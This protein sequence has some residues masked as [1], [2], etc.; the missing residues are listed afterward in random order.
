MTALKTSLGKRPPAKSRPKKTLIGARSGFSRA[1]FG[2][3]AGIFAIVGIAVVGL[4]HASSEPASATVGNYLYAGQC[5]NAGKSFSSNGVDNKNVSA[6]SQLVMQNDGN[7]VI[8]SGAGKAVWSTRTTGS[9]NRACL[10]G[11][12]NFI[13]FS[14]ASKPLW[15]SRTNGMLQAAQLAN[16]TYAINFLSASSSVIALTNAPKGQ[17]FYPS[18]SSGLFWLSDYG[19]TLWL[20]TNTALTPNHISQETMAQNGMLTSPNGNYKF[21]FTSDGNLVILN[22]SNATIWASGINKGRFLGSSYR[23]GYGSVLATGNSLEPNYQVTL[24]SWYEPTQQPSELPLGLSMQNDGNLVFY[25]DH[26]HAL[27]QSGTRGK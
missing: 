3:I 16:T 22:A 9:H 15:Y 18:G 17:T 13:V 11:D 24:G 21:H 25:G 4:S 2:L 10:Q 27:W 19:S 7:L 14:S 5:L 1:Q 12:G 20:T 26:G 8:Y 6:P 23:N